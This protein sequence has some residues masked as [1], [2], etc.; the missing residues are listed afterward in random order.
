MQ[1]QMKAERQHDSGRGLESPGGSQ[2]QGLNAT[3]VQ[4]ANDPRSA[5]SA[6]LSSCALAEGCNF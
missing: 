5:G 6:P 4:L 3:E 2:K 1:E